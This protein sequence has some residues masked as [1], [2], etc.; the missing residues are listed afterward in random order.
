MA[1]LKIEWSPEAKHDLFDIL[2]FY[3]HRNGSSTYSKKLN[4]KIQKSVLRISKHPQLG[5]KTNRPSVRS[6]ITD[7]YQIV[8][9]IF[10]QLVLIVMIW[11]CRRN[12]EEKLVGDRVVKIKT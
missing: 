12:P 10:D 9:E 2:G 3:I 1:K 5:M 11:D 4:S 8:Y 6:L 7:E